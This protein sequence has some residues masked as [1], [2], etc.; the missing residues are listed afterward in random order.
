MAGS[1][2]KTVVRGLGNRWEIV[3]SKEIEPYLIVCDSCTAR[4]KVRNASAIGQILACPKCGSMVKVIPP[5]GWSPPRN[6]SS[7]SKDDGTLLPNQAKK[8]TRKPKIGVETDSASGP[9]NQFEEI[10]ALLAG[11]KVVARANRPTGT[12]PSSSRLAARQGSNA[13]PATSAI[14]QQVPNAA[15]GNKSYAAAGEGP[16]L[17]TDQ[18]VGQQTR[19]RQKWLLLVFGLLAII[20]TGGILVIAMISGL[21]SGNQVASKDGEQIDSEVGSTEITRATE[22]VIDP[23]ISNTDS[24][25]E[26]DNQPLPEDADQERDVRS[27]VVENG[28]NEHADL[29]DVED[30]KSDVDVGRL[31]LDAPGLDRPFDVPS[32]IA[33]GGNET[34]DD[35]PKSALDG[36]KFIQELLAD[37]Q[38]S[39]SLLEQLRSDQRVEQYG[40]SRFYVAK[41]VEFVVD[42]DRQL[43]YFV[44]GFKAKTTLRGLLDRL[45]QIGHVP[46]TVDVDSVVALEI[47]LRKEMEVLETEKTLSEL[48]GH[49]LA[50][51]ELELVSDKSGAIVVARSADEITQRTYE[52]PA[53]DEYSEADFEGMVASIKYI[54]PNEVWDGSV[55][56][57]CEIVNQQL[58]V[59][60]RNRL[61]WKIEALFDKINAAHQLK[62]NPEDFQAK[63]VVRPIFESYLQ[64][65]PIILETRWLMLQ[66]LEKVFDQIERD[67]GITVIVDWQSVAEEGWNPDVQVPWAPD[68]RSLAAM[69]DDLAHAMKL[70]WRVINQQLIVLTTRAKFIKDLVIEVYPL[71]SYP[72]LKIESTQLATAIQNQLSSSLATVPGAIIAFQPK[73]DCFIAVMPQD[74]QFQLSQTLRRLN[75][76]P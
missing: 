20:V 40:M 39:I 63:Q 28:G 27:E 41:P 37:D 76:D 34:L 10:D 1:N 43:E 22:G 25:T 12:I 54:F 66:R 58:I 16:V 44:H 65:K 38:Q 74:L 72:N 29:A 18:W 13:T 11:Q 52:I 32:V 42:I 14:R 21:V 36:L 60:H 49:Q 19:L 46:F 68:G 26:T 70:E 8:S 3:L 24:I 2:L 47:E 31:P 50:S 67:H 71:S 75:G 33:E 55:G 23:E 45:Y 59:R 15:A 62:A 7:V 73:Y 64:L 51:L 4:L 30:A 35:R 48:I 9:Q 57:T 5:D 69:M 6:S 61:H 56:E 53:A 17:P